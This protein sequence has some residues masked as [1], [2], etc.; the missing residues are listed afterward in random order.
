[1]STARGVLCL[2]LALL[3]LVGVFADWI[4]GY[5][6]IAM[7]KG[8]HWYVLPALTAP[9]VARSVFIAPSEVTSAVWPPIHTADAPN[10][11]P[12]PGTSLST[13]VV[14]WVHGCRHWFVTTAGTLSLAIPGGLL[15]GSLGALGRSG[16]DAFVARAAEFGGM[17]PA[18]LFVA[19]AQLRLPHIP[20]AAFI[21]TLGGLGAV[22]FGRIVSDR[23][24]QVAAEPFV[25][26][27]RAVGASR[28]RLFRVQIL[29]HLWPTVLSGSLLTGSA[30][31]S[32]DTAL[33]FLGLQRGPVVP[34]WGAWLGQHAA[35]G[36]LGL[37]STPALL[38]FLLGTGG[39]ALLAGPGSGRVPDPPR[40]KAL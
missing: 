10:V 23:V 20:T 5:Y 16:A 39:L 40:G 8:G 18:V 27:A 38:G 33:G 4:A 19:F 1:M 24:T 14:W 37:G 9:E 17:L 2:L 34:S 36:T 15:L 6:P 12:G 30:V 32:I 11:L 29:P 3:A 28:V 22:A 26:A 35:T 7:A 21:V 25:L 31:A 13:A